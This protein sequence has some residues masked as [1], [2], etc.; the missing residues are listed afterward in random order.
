[1]AVITGTDG[2]DNLSG[3]AGD[4]TIDGGDDA[5]KDVLIGG[6]G[7]DI[8]V[9][10][11][12]K[13]TIT[14]TGK[15]IGDYD[16]IQFAEDFDGS[17]T[18]AQISSYLS[19]V[20]NIEAID[21]G[22]LISDLNITGNAAKTTVIY[23]GTGDDSLTGGTAKDALY[24]GAGN[25]T[26]NAGNDK[27][28][29]RLDGGK[30]DDTYI[31]SN[32]KDYIVDEGGSNTIKLS[33]SFSANHLDL[34]GG[35]GGEKALLGEKDGPEEMDYSGL[36]ITTIDASAVGK[37]LRL[38]A[39]SEDRR[40]N[41]RSSYI[42]GIEE[43][44]EV[45][46]DVSTTILGG[47]GKDTITGFEGNDVFFG[48]AGNDVIMGDK[49]NDTLDGGLGS[50]T[51]YGGRGNDSIAGGVGD[52]TIYG[53]DNLIDTRSAY[54][55]DEELKD[56]RSYTY[57]AKGNVLTDTTIYYDV[58]TGNESS[59]IVYEYTYDSDGNRLTYDYQNL[60]SEGEITY[61]NFH[62]YDYDLGGN[63]TKDEYWQY[64]S[65]GDVSYHTLYTYA[66]DINGNQTLT[67][68]IQYVGDSM[69]ISSHTRY[70][71]TYDEDGNQLT[72]DYRQYDGEDVT[73]RNLYTYEYDSDGN[74]TS[75]DYMR[76]EDGVVNSH[77]LTTS[78]YGSKGEQLSEDYKSF[79][80]DTDTVLSHTLY[81]YT[82]N[83]AGAELTQD[84]AQYNGGSDDINYHELNTYTYDS[85]A[86]QLSRDYK[87]YNSDEEVT[88]H[89]L[90]TYTYDAKGNRLTD[91]Y[92][93]YNADTTEITSHRL[94]TYAYDSNGN[95]TKED[96]KN[97]DVS[98]G[99]VSSRRL[100][101]YAYDANGNQLKEEYKYY[102]SAG[103]V[104]DR[105]LY[106]YAYDANGHMIK[107][108]YKEYGENGILTDRE[109]Y[110]YAYDASGNRLLEDY[111]EYDVLTGAVTYHDVDTYTY[112]SNGNEL[113]HS[114]K[115]YDENG[116]ITDEDYEGYENT[117]HDIAD[118][119]VGGLGN[120]TYFING[121]EDVIVENLN[122]GTDTV[123]LSDFNSR[124]YELADNVENLDASSLTRDVGLFGNGLA[125][126]ITGGS[127]GDYINGGSGGDKMIGGFG[128]D[129]YYVDSYKD[130]VVEGKNAGD[131]TI[132]IREYD[133]GKTKSYTLAANVENLD[134]RDI[135][136]ELDAK[137][138]ASLLKSKMSI[139]GN[140]SDNDIYLSDD[141]GQ[142]MKTFA[143]A[144]ADNI[145]GSSV[146][147][148]IDGGAGNDSIS[149]NDG[150]DTLV[151]GAG[152][153]IYSF[154]MSD[155]LD[156][157]IATDNTDIIQ[158][159]PRI[160]AIEDFMFYK[161]TKGNFYID[162]TNGGAGEDIISI[163]KGKYNGDTTIQVGEDSIH[164]NDIIT[165]LGSSMIYSDAAIATF[166]TDTKEDQ[167]NLLVG[168]GGDWGIE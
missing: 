13:D 76:Y 25:D 29:D 132:Y 55:E 91:D 113:T 160:S 72:D 74:Q 9:I 54:N 46:A 95:M 141:F 15:T 147:D 142:Y 66:Y 159:G 40:S 83:A 48:N 163:A 53:Y 6:E 28:C 106:V 44:F 84:F 114:Y 125:N 155:G 121:E 111:K 18:S 133:F 130:T 16:V 92:K 80:G 117:Y 149:G 47:K 107:E 81:T 112:D 146:N 12:L 129:D 3:T 139:N 164:I 57:D 20:K 4:D 41:V 42:R 110:T 8:Y 156:V 30:G 78:T 168:V 94:Y 19:K 123:K 138:I 127:G 98:T 154:G 131:D 88:S 145:A 90:Y 103:V 120:D 124:G 77:N 68:E 73:Y 93:R 69:D 2:I 37:G 143:G 31:L 79:D 87:Y 118:T 59:R 151:G 11:D 67:D 52:D 7:D 45:N 36:N 97:Y 166:N 85:N 43:D 167:G 144:G 148:Y 38:L 17:I 58:T 115:E 102:N 61:R 23:G 49:G 35:S 134:L 153:D 56:E 33:S 150:N 14:E 100:Y 122:G 82:Y 126:I 32:L 158:I 34:S 62:D 51:L 60:D 161:D 119:L 165:T 75:E 89:W 65:N 105:D 104:T 50:D 152:A 108:D 99:A 39:N 1:M 70:V 86:N 21:A 71:Y 10:H 137:Q 96:Y 26:L 162:Y 63:M 5:V 64:N 27:I 157:I 109:L 24:G 135:D 101:T 136:L 128:G 116:E 22:L 140:A